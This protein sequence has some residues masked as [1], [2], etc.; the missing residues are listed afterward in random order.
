MPQQRKKISC[1]CCTK[2]RF[3]FLKKAIG[4]YEA[5]DYPDKEL[6][7][8]N[9]SSH[10]I[11][12]HESLRN[13][14][15]I[16]L[17]N[18]GEFTNIK[19]VY[20][21]A[22]R[23]CRGEYTAIWDDDDFYLPWHLSTAVKYLDEN[24]DAQAFKPFWQHH[25]HQNK[26]YVETILPIANSCEGSNVVRTNLLK[27]VGF[28]DE[29]MGDQHPHPRWQHHVKQWALA[30]EN[31]ISYAYVWNGPQ[32]MQGHLTQ[33][34]ESFS[35]K[36][37]DY[38]NQYEQMIAVDPRPDYEKF[39]SLVK[40]KKENIDGTYMEYS[41]KELRALKSRLLGKGVLNTP[42]TDF[43]L[44]MPYED[45]FI[46]DCGIDE[47]VKALQKCLE[48]VRELSGATLEI[49]V[50]K[51]G[52]TREVLEFNY[53][54]GLATP[55]IA[56]DPY[57]IIPYNHSDYQL[58]PTD[59]TSKEYPIYSNR[60]GNRAFSLIYDLAA[61]YNQ[62]VLCLKFEDLE[63]FDRF[64]GGVPFYY[65]GSKHLVDF[66]KFVYIDGQ[67]TTEANW[68]AFDF[69]KYR[70]PY[71]GI[72]MF[73]DIANF[74]FDYL[75]PTFEQFSYKEIFRSNTRAAYKRMQPE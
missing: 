41:E 12:L 56:I 69:F 71:G 18:A 9:N 62:N 65:Q 52:S 49:G 11:D 48:E 42:H 25:W 15:D 67:H 7:I 44:E 10:S 23:F 68:I 53:E 72:I 8:F 16:R 58:L 74:N 37:T 32:H 63:F 40:Y 51:G 17:I 5:Q 47:N 6:I 55:H 60:L 57:G 22:V 54:N 73:D 33:G 64:A 45:F 59:E 31:E 21:S 50:Y 1:L 38:G 43:I 66:Y 61:K 75:L 26:D 19:D 28:G 13:R 34:F 39:L 14:R 20:N 30:N 4:F 46:S 27:E 2:G 70:I 36:N 35:E 29:G 3:N 24:P